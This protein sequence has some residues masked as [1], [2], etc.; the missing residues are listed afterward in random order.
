[1]YFANRW[2]F[3]GLCWPDGISQKRT[4]MGL[5]THWPKEI[6][7]LSLKK[8]HAMNKGQKTI[9][10]KIK[11]SDRKCMVSIFSL[12]EFWLPPIR[13]W[14]YEHPSVEGQITSVACV[15]NGV[16]VRCRVIVLSL[17]PIGIH[18]LFHL[19]LDQSDEFLWQLPS[20]EYDYEHWKELTWFY[21]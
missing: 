16:K 10:K 15:P 11:N 9:Y 7:Y 6:R 14:A 8:G 2:H 13:C 4:N 20:R 3:Q 5:E 1:M 12:K 18:L 21:K 19:Y 17:F